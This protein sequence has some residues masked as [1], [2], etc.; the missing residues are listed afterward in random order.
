MQRIIAFMHRFVAS[1]HR[2]DARKHRFDAREH[3]FDAREHRF[4]ARKHRFDARE[5]RFDARKHRFDACKHRFDA[6]EHRF[7]AREHRFDARKHR[8][9]ARKH[10]FDAREH[11]FDARKHRFDARKHRFDARKHR[12]D[13]R[14]HRFDARKHHSRRPLHLQPPGATFLAALIYAQ[15]RLPSLG[16]GARRG[17]G[18]HTPGSVRRTFV[19]ADGAAG[20]LRPANDS[21]EIVMPKQKDLK[22]LFRPRMKKGGDSS[23]GPRL[24]LVRK[25]EPPPDYAALAGLSDAAVEK[26]TGRNWA[27]WVAL[28]DAAHAAEK[29]HREIAAHVSSLGTPSWWSQTVT[30]GYERIRG[31]RARGQQR[32]G[33]YQA[34]K[35]RT[36]T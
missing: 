6:R 15:P 23:P 34:T 13:V 9:D 8:F 18:G 14:K 5:H 32:S 12:F 20:G 11:R 27:S 21:K 10:R 1:M 4:D 28:L 26:N 22:R 25:V 24:Q 30:V 29:P 7:D 31:L 17:K 33:G 16:E 2:F 3:R 36:I 19:L 35:S